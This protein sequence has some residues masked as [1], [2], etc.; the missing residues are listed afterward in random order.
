MAAVCCF[1]PLSS[2]HQNPIEVTGTATVEMV[3]LLVIPPC[4]ICQLFGKTGALKLC[5]FTLQV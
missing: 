3:M 4:V 5:L 1:W 2:L